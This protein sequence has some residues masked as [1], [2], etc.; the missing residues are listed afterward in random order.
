MSTRLVTLLLFT[1]FFIARAGDDNIICKKLLPGAAIITSSEFDIGGPQDLFDGDTTTLARSKNINPCY[2]QM[3]F[4]E[5][6]SVDSMH[7]YIGQYNTPGDTDSWMIETADNLADMESK[8]GSHF[9]LKHKNDPKPGGWDCL[10]LKSTYSARIWKFTMFRDFGDGYVH[11]YEL[12]LFGF[13]TPSAMTNDYPLASEIRANNVIYKSSGYI[14]C[15]PVFDGSPSTYFQFT[16][17]QESQVTLYFVEPQAFDRARVLFKNDCSWRVGWADTYADVRDKTGTYTESE[18]REAEADKWDSLVTNLPPGKKYW[19][20]MA[21][22]PLAV[23][24]LAEIDFR[25]ATPPETLSGLS[26]KL[27]LWESWRW[28]CA[29]QQLLYYGAEFVPKSKVEWKSDDEAVAKV[30][31]NGVITALKAGKANITAT[32]KGAVAKTEVTVLAPVKPM[33]KEPLD[34]FLSTA[35]P[36]HIFE[37]PILIV[38]YLPTTDGITKDPAYA[39]D[40][41]DLSKI[42]LA[43]SKARTSEGIHRF[44]FA[45]EQGSRFRGYKN[46]AAPSSIGIKVV[47]LITIYE[48]VPPGLQNGGY[49]EGTLQYSYDFDAMFERFNFRDYVENKGVK[50]IWIWAGGTQPYMS[51]FDFDLHK[52]EGACRASFESYMSTPTDVQAMN[53]YN[54]EPLPV[55]SKTYTVIDQSHFYP[56]FTAVNFEPFTHQFES[57]L[58]AQNNLQDGDSHLFWDKFVGKR[59]RCGWTHTPPNTDINYGYFH[60]IQADTNRV[61]PEWCDIE[62]WIPAGG[63]KSLISYHNWEDIHYDWPDG[64][65]N[66]GEREELQ[67]FIYWLQAIPGYEN[68]IPYTVNERKA[69]MTN[70]WRFWYDWDAYV[71]DEYALWEYDDVSAAESEESTKFTI[72]P[73]PASGSVVIECARPSTATVYSLLGEVILQTQAP[74]ELNVSSLP[75]GIYTINIGSK[76]RI[77]IKQ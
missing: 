17:D 71:H 75:A 42:S 58:F 18:L 4:P 70:W 12:G 28:R 68:N 49:N 69:K 48:P 62:D 19:K 77:F 22:N 31:N 2:V 13:A 64:V 43:D 50:Q 16:G 32:Y 44:K 10:R 54:P 5:P 47:D 1:S 60:Y 57:L 7:I 53:G 45:I 39:P 37:M 72:Y 14:P 34:K 35:T 51:N 61:K 41:W 65:D 46:P 52:P 27:E 63:K 36:N 55:Y 29:Q 40:L 21:S 76:A 6:I 3:E 38:Q 33:E 20:F 59:N 11:V 23:V 56:S 67:W 9:Y 30:D 24:K 73:N 25:T 8:T 26:K 74:G 15:K 66:F